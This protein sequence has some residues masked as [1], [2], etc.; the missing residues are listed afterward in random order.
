MV[1]DGAGVHHGLLHVAEG[2]EQ[3][4]V[5]PGRARRTSRQELSII[6]VKD[7]DLVEYA[8]LV[9]SGKMHILI[10]KYNLHNCVCTV[11][12]FCRNIHIYLIE[13]AL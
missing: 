9:R 6:S 2:G 3:P 7:P 5:P 10:R 4:R 1:L 12:T 8:Y 11:C 13:G